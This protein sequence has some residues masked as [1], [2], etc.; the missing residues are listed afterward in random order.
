MIGKERLE[1]IARSVQAK[2]RQQVCR[3]RFIL[4]TQETLYGSG[5]A[6]LPENELREVLEF[7]EL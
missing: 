7:L 4:K 5:V 2:D 6:P 1:D 3:G